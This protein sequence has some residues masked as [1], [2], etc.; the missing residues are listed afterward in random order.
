MHLSDAIWWSLYSLVLP[1]FKIKNI[2]SKHTKT[3]GGVC[4]LYVYIS[5]WL[6]NYP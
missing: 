6:E 2:A 3:G 4:Y 1:F 5:I